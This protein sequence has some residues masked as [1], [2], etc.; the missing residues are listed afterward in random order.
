MNQN[1]TKRCAKCG[2]TLGAE[3]ISCPICGGALEISGAEKTAAEAAPQ[4]FSQPYTQK[5]TAIPQGVPQSAYGRQPQ[6]YPQQA[7]QF[8]QTQYGQPQAYPQQPQQF[9]QTQYGQAQDYPQQPQQF[10]QTQYGQAQGY[11]QQAQPFRQTQYGQPQGYPQ[12]AQQFGQ[13]QFG[14]PEQQQFVQPTGFDPS[15]SYQ[16]PAALPVPPKKSKAGLA[17][18]LSIAAVVLVGGGVVGVLA[19]NGV[20]SGDKGKDEPDVTD[21]TG[22]SYSETT[23][24]GINVVYLG[25]DPTSEPAGTAPEKTTAAKTSAA[26]DDTYDAQVLTTT[27]TENIY[28]TADT[29]AA[30]A[31]SMFYTEEND[32]AVELGEVTIYPREIY[33][34]E[35]GDLEAVCILSNGLEEEIIINNV[36]NFRIYDKKGNLFASGDFIGMDFSLEARMND[37]FTFIFD[38]ASGAVLN[39]SP[40]LSDVTLDY[41]CDHST[42]AARYYSEENKDTIV[43]GK[44]SFYPK[45]VYYDDD[46]NLCCKL[47]CGNGKDNAVFVTGFDY[48]RIQ[49]KDGDVIA[50]AEFSGI[51][52]TIAPNSVTE[53]EF[54]I[55]KNDNNTFRTVSEFKDPEADFSVNFINMGTDPISLHI[56]DAHYNDNYDL[57]LKCCIYNNLGKDTTLYFMSE[58]EVYD[59]DDNLIA[60]TSFDKLDKK[61]PKDSSIIYTFTVPSSD[62]TDYYADLSTVSITYSYNYED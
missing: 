31:A 14:Q 42:K 15:P 56:M 49:E 3:N 16:Q 45:E 24:G 28:T 30:P 1:I 33:F 21:D 60:T 39:D 48:L 23:D 40:D 55:S 51:C 25:S 19:M 46:G 38:A 13:T 47:Y 54:V 61:I 50:D 27:T 7:Q 58:F 34:T 4:T 22:T 53:Q 12:Q 35:N 2:I 44:L 36:K 9:G 43:S 59:A 10:G 20:F 11:P 37:S 32:Y 18:G 29:T 52:F 5:P 57:V 62:V 8:G 41:Q 6:G 17:V 26:P